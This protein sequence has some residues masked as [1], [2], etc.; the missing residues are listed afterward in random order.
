M[1]CTIAYRELPP[2][3]SGGHAVE[4]KLL[5]ASQDKAEIDKLVD[6]IKNQ[7]GSGLVIDLNSRKEPEN[8]V[9]D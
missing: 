7:Y 3:T 9:S 1:T 6:E 2:T 8:E 5:Y 4:V